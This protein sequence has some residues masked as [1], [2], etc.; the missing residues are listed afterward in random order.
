MLERPTSVTPTGTGPVPARPRPPPP[1]PPRPVSFAPACTVFGWPARHTAYPETPT[2][3]SMNTSHGRPRDLGGLAWRPVSAA[4]ASCTSV[5]V[6]V[7][8]SAR[9]TIAAR[10]TAGLL[11]NSTDPGTP[12][13]VLI[14]KEVR[15]AY[16]PSCDLIHGS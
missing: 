16:S 11:S 13:G 14:R 8:M 12:N 15:V 4:G 5:L 3:A 10:S 6:T 1:R 9:S 2:I 7:L